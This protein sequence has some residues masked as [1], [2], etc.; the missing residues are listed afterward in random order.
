M[1]T[2][3]IVGFPGETEQDFSETLALVEK[4]L[5]DSAYIFAYSPRPGTPA[6]KLEDDVTPAEKDARLQALM[7][8]QRAASLKRNQALLGSTQEVLFE[9]R[10][11]RDENRFV[12]RTRT[13]K[14]VV[15]SSSEDLCGQF[16]DVRIDAVADETLLGETVA[17]LRS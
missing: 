13:F 7:A 11:R 1:S 6:L 2:D 9:S 8:A 5:F 15:A 10:T 3:F 16:R 14:R 4:G 12:G 17:C